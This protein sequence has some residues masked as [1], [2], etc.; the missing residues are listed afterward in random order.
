MQD[1]F[2]GGTKQPLLGTQ[3]RI[4]SRRGA[5]VMSNTSDGPVSETLGF[6]RSLKSLLLS[7]WISFGMALPIICFK[8]SRLGGLTGGFTG[9]PPSS[10]TACTWAVAMQVAIH[11][12]NNKYFEYHPNYSKNIHWAEEFNKHLI[13]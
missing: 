10:R 2:G 4:P 9:V 3:R 6:I 5:L 7:S 1:V 8:V 13:P 11:P 12:P